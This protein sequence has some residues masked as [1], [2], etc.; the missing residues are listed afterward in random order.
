LLERLYRVR[1]SERVEDYLVTDPAMLKLLGHHLDDHEVREKLLV[2][3]SPGALDISLY[4][5]A[6]VLKKL[7][8]QN[9]LEILN[10]ENLHE[11][12][13]A[14]EGVSHF[15]YLVYKALMEDTVTRFELEMQAEIDKYVITLFL[16]RRQGSEPQVSAIHRSLFDSPRFHPCL[17][18]DNLQRYRDANRYAGKYCN[19]L[20]NRYIHAPASNGL[21]D[22]LRD[23]YR[24]NQRRKVRFVDTLQ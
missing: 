14:L 15:V 22:E 11:F 5:D 18:S 1:L 10:G 21:I 8:D 12:L 19:S 7:A 2:A 17:T 3:E 9:P 6:T 13:I 20:I 23:F 24:L 4:I 16:L